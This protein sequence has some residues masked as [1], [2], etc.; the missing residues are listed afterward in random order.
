MN[1]QQELNKYQLIVIEFDLV[2]NKCSLQNPQN[3]L[4]Y[5]RNI[6]E[7]YTWNMLLTKAKY[8]K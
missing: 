3:M 1:W 4:R 7:G 5:F 2:S 6:K 8:I